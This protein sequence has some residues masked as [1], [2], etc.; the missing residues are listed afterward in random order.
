[1]TKWICKVCGYVHEGETAPAECPICHAKSDKFEKMGGDI[2]WAADGF[3]HDSRDGR[4][5]R[6][7][8]NGL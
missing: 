1:M 4:G 6:S 7:G 2:S 5:T 3:L 8:E